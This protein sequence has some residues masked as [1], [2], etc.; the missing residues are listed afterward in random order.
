MLPA[1]QVDAAFMTGNVAQVFLRDDEW[2]SVLQATRRALR[3]NGCLVFEAR[4]PERR[5]WERWTP[6]LTHRVVEVP[7]VGEVESW[8]ELAEANDE[9]V[10][11]RSMRVFLR[12]DVVL[13]STSTLRFRA[14]SDLEASLLRNGF[15]VVEVRDAL[16]RPGLEHVFIARAQGTSS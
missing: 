2:S 5:A 10:T 4:V 9:L 12:D 7:G 1:L 13:E 6:E 8:D 15:E 14:R 3:P 11:F 16:D